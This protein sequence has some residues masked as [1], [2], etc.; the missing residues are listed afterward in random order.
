VAERRARRGA[1]S[2]IVVGRR[3]GLLRTLQRRLKE[4]GADFKKLVNETR[5]RFALRYLQDRNNTLTEVA[6]LLGYA[7]VSAFNRAFKRWTRTTPSEYRR[8]LASR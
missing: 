7:E 1:A 2:V 6:Y 4:Q 3:T 8:G 5:R